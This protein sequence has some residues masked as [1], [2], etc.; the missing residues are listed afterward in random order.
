MDTWTS[1]YF[2]AATGHSFFCFG[3]LSLNGFSTFLST[4]SSGMRNGRLSY[5]K[6]SSFF[7][8]SFF[9]SEGLSHGRSFLGQVPDFRGQLGIYGTKLARRFWIMLVSRY[10][11]LISNPSLSASPM[12]A[13]STLGAWSGVLIFRKAWGWSPLASHAS[14]K[15]KLWQMTHL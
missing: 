5:S 1:S 9:S 12:E 8:F 10:F 6:G 7:G 13:I 11:S 4:V 2:S 15:S 14:Q 3:T